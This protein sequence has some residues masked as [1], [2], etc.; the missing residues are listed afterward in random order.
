MTDLHAVWGSENDGYVP[1]RTRNEEET[2]EC[3]E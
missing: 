3:N 2:R 1:W